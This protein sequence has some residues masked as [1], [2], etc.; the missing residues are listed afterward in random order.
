MRCRRV[1][2][3][4][5]AAFGFTAFQVNHGE[6]REAYGYRFD[7]P[8]KTIVISGDT[9]PS[10]ELVKMATGVDILIHEVQPSDSTKLPPNRTAAEWAAYVSQYHTTALQLGELAARA[11]PKLLV[12]YHNGRRASDE[13]ILA[14]IRKAWTGPVVLAADLQRF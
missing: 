1:S 2:S 7:G 13:E 8:G 9:R 14:D 11:H 10:D 12:V 6:W 5:A 4:T 3:T